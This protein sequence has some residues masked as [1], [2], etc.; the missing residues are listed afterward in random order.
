VIFAKADGGYAEPMSEKLPANSLSHFSINVAD[1]GRAIG[2]Y[3]AV[4]DWKF[5]AWGPPGFNLIEAPGP[6]HGSIQ[7]AQKEPFETFI[8]NFE[9]TL[10]VDDVDRVSALIVANGG[11]ITLPKVTIPGVADI[12]R[13]KDTEGNLFSIARYL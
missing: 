11:E 13:C 3:G 12:A 5:Q 2:F 10:A 7:Q 6:V 9:C 4:F 1:M 8:G